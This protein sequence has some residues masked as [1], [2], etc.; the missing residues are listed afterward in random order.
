MQL[1]QAGLSKEQVLATLKAYKTRDVPWR[2]GRVMAGIYDPGSAAEEVGKAAYTEFLT[3]NA[4]YPNFFPSLL[5]LETDTVRIVAGLLQG[6]PQT[7]GT[8]TSGG[9]ESILLAVK[10]AR[11][12][13]RAHKPHIQVPEMVLCITAH[14]AFHKAAHYLGFQVRVTPMNPFTFRADVEAMREAISENT[15]LLVGSAP[16]YSHGV[17]DPIPEI[18]ALAQEKGILCHVDA[19]VGGIHLSVMRE[20]GYAVPPFDLST[21]GVTSLSTDL[22]KYG[23][24]A[25][26]VSVILFHNAPLRRFAM[27][28]CAHTTGYAVIN[29][30]VLSSKSGGPM[31]GAWATMNFLG[32][33][34]YKQIVLEVQQAT[35]CMM[36][37]IAAIPELEVLGQPDMC[38][39][40]FK[41]DSL[42]V[43]ELDDAMAAR[44]WFL[45]PQ[46]SAGG[47]P[48]NLHISVNRSNVTH[49][50]E[51]LAALRESVAEVKDQGSMEDVEQLK[52]QVMQ[53]LQNPGPDT[54]AQIAALA[55]I[56]PGQMPTGFA[57]INTVLDMLPDEMVD[58]LLIEYLNSLYV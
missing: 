23:Y 18:A 37:G 48:A 6:A 26:N 13:A 44:G 4:L 12:W 49:V 24:T 34:G 33:E 55:G 2:E 27:F 56:T 54:F 25:K 32:L 53:L 45:Q 7:V 30:T 28:A 19:C 11:D 35:Q 14:P 10:A 41:S 20:L 22:H 15:I 36:A 42:S 9:T 29:P 46:F 31:A 51:F 16:C 8:L 1:P 58:F 57:R 5:K 17:V 3:E 39:F 52:H 50:E 21:P 43:F 40:A 38:M 47:G